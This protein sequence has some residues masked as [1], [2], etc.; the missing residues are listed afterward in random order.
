MIRIFAQG[1]DR[2]SLTPEDAHHLVKVLRVTIGETIE[3]LIDEKVYLG[4]I[5]ALNPLTIQRGPQV[6]SHHEL[7]FAITLIYPLAKGERLDW[8]VQKATELGAHELIA[9]QSERTVVVWQNDT[10][11]QKLL[12]YHRIIAEATLQSKREK[13]MKMHQYL[14]LMEALKLSFDHRYIA[15]EHHRIEAISLMTIPA[16]TTGGNVAILIGPEGGFSMQEVDAAIAAGYQPVSL[17][18]RILR[19]E[20]AVT[21]ALGILSQKGL[22]Q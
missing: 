10:V 13:Q 5:T 12:R 17:G 21:V 16:I 20:T 14:P 9:C 22:P 18:E 19:T 3:L 15:S 7:P 2:V 4:T 8:V 6:N 11:K 1:Q